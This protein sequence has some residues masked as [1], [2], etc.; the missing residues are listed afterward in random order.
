M[1]ELCSLIVSSVRRRQRCEQFVLI[2]ANFLTTGYRK[3]AK[4][5]CFWPLL[6]LR[7]EW[8]SRERAKGTRAFRRGQMVSSFMMRHNQ[9]SWPNRCCLFMRSQDDT[10][11]QSRADQ[12]IG[13]I[14]WNRRWPK[15]EHNNKYTMCIKRCPYRALKPWSRVLMA[16]DAI[17]ESVS[18]AKSIHAWLIATATKIKRTRIHRARID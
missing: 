18:S 6:S 1:D 7:F 15:L 14:L 11:E 9:S 3:Q 16:S 10:T 13:S 17:F 2:L 5:Q 4:S 8:R 12:L